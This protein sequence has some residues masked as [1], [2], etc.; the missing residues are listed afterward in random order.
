MGAAETDEVELQKGAGEDDLEAWKA[1]LVK[2]RALL[3]VVVTATVLSAYVTVQ[4]VL[5]EVYETKASVLV[6]LGRENTEVPVTVQKGAVLSGGVRKEELNS[7]IQLLSARSLVTEVVDQIGSDAFRMPMVEP[8]TL[9]QKITHYVRAGVGWTRERLAALL[10]ATG[11]QKR[12][13]DRER[14]ILGIEG[15]LRVEAERDSDVITVRLQFGDPDLSVRILSLLLDL[16]LDRHIE[17]RRDVEI[18]GVFS[19]QVAAR[20]RLVEQIDAAREEIKAR[21]NL[22]STAEQRTMLLKQLDTVRN[23]IDANEAKRVALQAQQALM[24][25]RLAA[26]PDELRQSQSI[27]PNPSVQ[28][29]KDRL[30]LLQQER[31]KL[32]T[33]YLPESQVIRNVEREIVALTELLANEEPTLVG[34]ITYQANPVKASFMQ[35][36][37]EAGVQI[38][39]LES[40]RQQRG[41]RVREIEEQLRQ[42][43]EGERQIRDLERERQIAEESYLTYVKRMEESLIVE[44]L[45][46][47]RIANISVLSPPVRAI[48]A[49]YPRKLFIVAL[50]FPAGLLIGVAMVFLVEYFNDVISTPRDL[51]GIR[52]VAYLG[53]FRL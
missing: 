3:A 9:P 30:V 34:A 2:Y 40:S 38:A 37:E 52:G 15:A 1:A 17:V 23:E 44:E 24:R 36:I 19:R 11:L 48:E 35:S 10:V 53:G 7:E 16:Y 6:K 43:N 50:S 41:A 29:R 27:T 5:R 4:F 42:I 49:V 33:H 18:R 21:F 26:L 13:S 20:K 28:A 46:R 31:A 32:S 8:Q 12:L 47:R 14:L 25:G 22:V 45:D 51:A 39:G